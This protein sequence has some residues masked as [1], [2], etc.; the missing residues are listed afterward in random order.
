MNLD[1][2]KVLA[3]LDA[4]GGYL[5][6]REALLAGDFDLPSVPVG[7]LEDAL[8]LAMNALEQIKFDF[9]PEPNEKLVDEFGT[10]KYCEE[11][12]SR[13]YEMLKN[14]PSIPAGGDGNREAKNDPN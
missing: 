12:L 11:V 8:R 2:K 6:F 1:K 3:W 7:G 10:R 13:I 9:K 14:V 5:G 4:N